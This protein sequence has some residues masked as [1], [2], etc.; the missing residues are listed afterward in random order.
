M[1][2]TRTS[3]IGAASTALLTAAL[4]PAAGAD[5]GSLCANDPNGIVAYAANAVRQQ[6]PAPPAVIPGEMGVSV[7]PTPWKDAD[8]NASLRWRNLDTGAQGSVST[9]PLSDGLA[10][11]DRV[12]TQP[13]TVVFTVRTERIGIDPPALECH[14]SVRIS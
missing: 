11:F 8:W 7:I 10:I 2:V 14:S 3:V 12:P 13:G 9:A 1:H 6:A 5:V 4:A